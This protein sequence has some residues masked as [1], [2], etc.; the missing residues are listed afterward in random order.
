MKSGREMR[1][2]IMLNGSFKIINNRDCPY[3]KIESK[4]PVKSG[5]ENEVCAITYTQW[6]GSYFLFYCQ[7]SI[8]DFA[9]I[10]LDSLAYF[11]TTEKHHCGL[12]SDWLLKHLISIVFA[13][14]L[15]RL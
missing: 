13:I 14:Y 1:K 6:A 8:H 12:A 4:E 7:S 11:G 9:A 10:L 3:F 5:S 2:E 15:I